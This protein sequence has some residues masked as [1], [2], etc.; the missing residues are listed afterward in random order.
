[1]NAILNRHDEAQW[2]LIAQSLK[3]CTPKLQLSF[4]DYF[5]SFSQIFEARESIDSPVLSQ[6]LQIVRKDYHRGQW[7]AEI[8]Y[9]ITLYYLY[10][11]TD[12]LVN[13]ELYHIAPSVGL[14]HRWDSGFLAIQPDLTKT[15]L[16]SQNLQ[17]TIQLNTMS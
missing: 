7:Q 14:L 1:M 4:I 2:A 3:T 8:V 12:R 15:K 11:T 6:Q 13:W 10:S 9:F 5:G 16:N 17:V